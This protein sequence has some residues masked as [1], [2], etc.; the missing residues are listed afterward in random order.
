MKRILLLLILLIPLSAKAEVKITNHLIDAEIEIAGGLRV[1]ELIVFDGN[2][3]DFSRTLN[4]KM[5]DDVW[6]QKT[7]NFSDGSMYNGYSLENVKV[8]VT[9]APNDIN[10]DIFKEDRDNYLPILD[11]KNKNKT[12]SFYTNIKNSL[13]ST[14]NIHSVSKE[15]AIAYYIEYVIS[16]VILV[17]ND[18]GELN[19]TFKNLD[20]GASN[21][22]IRLIIPY[23]TDSDVYNFW[24]HGPA[25]GALQ[26][27][28]TSSGD[29][30]GVITEFANLKNDVNFRMT[31]P[32]EQV[33]IDIYLN[34]TNTDALDKILEIENAKL[35]NN[36]KVLE[37]IK[38]SLIVVSIIYVIGSFI[39]IK[40]HDKS[41]FKLYILLGSILTLFNFIFKYHII[42][43]YFILLFPVTINFINKKH[44]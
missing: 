9:A 29:K 37:I 22:I 28:V 19:Y 16:N 2:I 6:D 1:K 44:L 18:V 27:V 40:Y 3:Q 17:H 34:K 32:K 42:Y 38:Y 11:P 39:L 7:I 31:L 26:E 15:E 5:I 30:I 14:I 23:S 24:V 10:F 12:N 36:D 20:I 13:G 8:A 41:I 25:S 35:K 21:T 43:L 4:Y 33:G